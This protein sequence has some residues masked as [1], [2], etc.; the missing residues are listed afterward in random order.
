MHVLTAFAAEPAAF[1]HTLHTE[2]GVSKLKDWRLGKREK[3]RKSYRTLKLK[4]PEVI[5]A[6]AS[7][8]GK[9]MDASFSS[10]RLVM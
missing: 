6:P 4:Q 2:S 9:F 1:R 5:C 7:L 3:Y 10:T 8:S